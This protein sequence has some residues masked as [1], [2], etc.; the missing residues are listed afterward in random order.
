MAFAELP[1]NTN[2]EH[3]KKQ[4]K[5]LLKAVRAGD[6]GARARVGPY[7]GDPAA[8]GLQYAQ[9]VIAREYGLSSWN[10]LK[11]EVE[12]TTARAAPSADRLANKFLD[13]V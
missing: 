8:I 9:L 12:R 7:F 5:A 11:A 13:L 2:L 1:E 10:K 4:A 6:E 3:L